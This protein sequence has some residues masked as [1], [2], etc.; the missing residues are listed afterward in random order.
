MTPTMTPCEQL[1]LARQQ[2][3]ML[4]SGRATV[5]VETPQLGRVE[6]S[7]GSVADLQRLID[8][9][10]ADCAVSQGQ[11][12]APRRRPINIEAWP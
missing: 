1:A 7:P 10:A 8:T 12:A 6:F 2:M 3:L 5:A 9:L 11:A 4:M